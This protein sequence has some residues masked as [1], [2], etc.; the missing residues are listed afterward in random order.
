MESFMFA[1]IFNVHEAAQRITQLKEKAKALNAATIKEN[2]D[3]TD[4]EKVEYD[5]TLREI[6]DV[7]AKIEKHAA[8]G[9]TGLARRMPGELTFV[10][11]D[12][13]DGGSGTGVSDPRF[14][15]SGA[16]NFLKTREGGVR[17]SLADGSDLQ[18]NLPGHQVLPFVRAYPGVDPLLDAGSSIQDLPSGWV[19]ANVPIIVAGT[20]PSTYGEGAGPTNDEP[21]N[22]YV[23]QL[24]NS[25]KYAFLCKITE[26]AAQ[27]IDG[28]VSVLSQ[29]G[30]RRIY[31]KVTKA[32]TAALIT[33]LGTANAFITREMDNLED[34]L[35]LIAAIPPYFAGPDNVWMGSRATLA[36]LRNTR[37]LQNR[38]LFDPQTGS[39]LSY[40]FIVNDYVPSGKLLFGNFRNGVYLRRS[41]IALQQLLEAY[42]EAG[43]N[44][45]RFMQRAD[46]A[47]FAEAATAAQAEQPIYML[48]SDFGS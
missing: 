45:L 4:G 10:G 27:D 41:G 34:L 36:L 9:S 39:L 3:F 22:V 1:G 16:A 46:S 37:D 23:A 6:N 19:D 29:E 43:K 47:F 42:K 13:E 32:T 18:Y 26:E 35:T 11:S 21:A 25:A 20:D 40:R 17:A 33:A 12:T 2:R 15:F 31:N 28:I 44:G 38:P 8:A 30:I 14:Q 5:S 48:T 24:K 7:R